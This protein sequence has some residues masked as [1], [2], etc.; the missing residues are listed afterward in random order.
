MKIKIDGLTKIIKGNEILKDVNLEFESGKI[1]GL[2]GKNGSGKT[3]LLKAI[4]GLIFPTEGSVCIDGSVIGKDIDFPR[5]MG[6]LI[7][8]PYFIGRY[9]AERNLLDLVEIRNKVGI[10]EIRTILEE[11]GLKNEPKKKFRNYSLGMKQKL[12]IAAALVEKPSLILLDEPTN[13]LDE[14]GVEKLRELLVERREKG[15]LI[16]IASHDKEE[17]ALLCDEVYKIEE[18]RIKGKVSA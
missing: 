5:D 15:A 18:G 11:V 1:Y 2:Q 4:S 14:A 13:A 10:D 9:N 3:M 7:E 6:I 16:I 8:N 12:G 17:M